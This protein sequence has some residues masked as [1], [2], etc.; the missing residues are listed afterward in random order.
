MQGIDDLI[1]GTNYVRNPE[2]KKVTHHP[3]AIKHLIVVKSKALRLAI[4]GLNTAAFGFYEGMV[5][6]TQEEAIARARA[7]IASEDK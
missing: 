3:K 5:F 1:E 7:I 6:A 2:G 4:K